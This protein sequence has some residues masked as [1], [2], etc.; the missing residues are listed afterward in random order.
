MATFED[1]EREV[2]GLRRQIRKL[3]SDPGANQQAVNEL[4]DAADED[5]GLRVQGSGM[6]RLADSVRQQARSPET[7]HGRRRP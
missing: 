1:L 3:E 6:S 2:A 7:F 5:P 4:T